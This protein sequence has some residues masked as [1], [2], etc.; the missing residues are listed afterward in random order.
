MIGYSY[1][2]GVLLSRIYLHALSLP[3]G[4]SDE[5]HNTPS[6]SRGSDCRSTQRTGEMSA[7]KHL[8]CLRAD[9]DAPHPTTSYSRRLR[10]HRALTRS[11]CRETYHI[12]I[13][14]SQPIPRHKEIS[15]QDSHHGFASTAP[16]RLDSQLLVLQH[17]THM[18]R[19]AK[20]PPRAV[21]RISISERPTLSFPYGRINWLTGPA[22][23]IGRWNNKKVVLESANQWSAFVF[24]RSVI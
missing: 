22:R 23:W 7:P 13:R 5:R 17:T 19:S 2:N 11:N 12:K 6:P 3:S 21:S 8:V 16:H 4:F 18:L 9:A 1:R 15:P 14:S 24:Y 20:S 10:Q